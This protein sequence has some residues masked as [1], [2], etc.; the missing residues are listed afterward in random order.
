M[1]NDSVNIWSPSENGHLGPKYVGDNI[2]YNYKNDI[3]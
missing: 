2:V 3:N 1:L